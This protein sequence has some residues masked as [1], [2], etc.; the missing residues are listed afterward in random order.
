MTRSFCLVRRGVLGFD[1]CARPRHAV[2]HH[3]RHVA[4]ATGA[5]QVQTVSSAANPGALFWQGVLS[6]VLN[7]KVAIFFLAFLPQ[8]VDRENGNAAVQMFALG[9]IFAFFGLCFL[10]T[11]GI[12]A[13]ALGKW[14]THRPHYTDL[15][16]CLASSILVILGIRLT[17]TERA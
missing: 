17:L 14:L 3:A 9:M 2:R 6:N 13:G 1:C 4:W 8:F 12:S 5:F 11:I 10:V 15:L 16:R 7:P